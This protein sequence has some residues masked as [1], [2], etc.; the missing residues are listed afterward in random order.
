MSRDYVHVVN[1]WVEAD[2]GRYYFFQSA[3]NP[4]GFVKLRPDSSTNTLWGTGYLRSENKVK[5][6]SHVHDWQISGVQVMPT[7]GA[8]VSKTRR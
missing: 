3:S 2:R 7:T 5:G 8:S 4:F 1:P 6:L